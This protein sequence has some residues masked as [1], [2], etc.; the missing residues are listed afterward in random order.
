MGRR[1]PRPKQPVERPAESLAPFDPPADL[2]LLARKAWDAYWRSPAA[3]FVTHG[4]EVILI[5]WITLVSRYDVLSNVA[6]RDPIVH[7][8]TGQTRMNPAYDLAMKIAVEI[9]AL[10]GVLNIGPVH[11]AR[12]G[13]VAPTERA[14]LA[15]VNAA[16]ESGEAH[17]DDPRVITLRP[18]AGA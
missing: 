15:D 1:G 2:S 13:T 4:D 9:R 10:E 17:D 8:S 14:K 18:D 6:D 11:R 16:Y 3:G 12:L 5:R 7:G